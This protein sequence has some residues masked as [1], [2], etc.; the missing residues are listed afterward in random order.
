MGAT[1]FDRKAFWEEKI[2]GWEGGRYGEGHGEPGLLQRIADWS[3]D[4]LRFRVPFAAEQLAPFVQGRT[5]VDLGCGSGLLT[6]PLLE[7]G[8]RHVRGI[9]IAESAIVAARARAASAGWGDRASFEVGTIEGLDRLEADVVV[10]LGLTDWL[11]DEELD[12]LFALGGDA[13]VLH[14]YSELRPSITQLA[15]RAY[16]WTSYGLRTRGY[17]PRYFDTRDFAG[18]MVRQRPGPA[19]VVRHP[20]LTFGAF[21]TSLPI[22]EPV[23]PSTP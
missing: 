7:A 11:T 15:H 21:L 6:G 22:G 14:A 19:A 10:S 8:A 20:R 5:V 4:S 17:V 9:D 2:L 3:S 12:H 23:E 1:G 16:C 13:H 18:R